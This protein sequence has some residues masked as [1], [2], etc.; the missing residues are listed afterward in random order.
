MAGNL[1]VVIYRLHSFVKKGGQNKVN[2]SDFFVFDKL[3]LQNRANKSGF[4]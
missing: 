4:V 3:T 1:H 2:E